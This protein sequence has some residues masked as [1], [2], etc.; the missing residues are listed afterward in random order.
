MCT[1]RRDGVKLGLPLSWRAYGLLLRAERPA[2]WVA[3]SVGQWPLSRL[4]SCGVLRPVPAGSD[5]FF[6]GSLGWNH[7]GTDPGA[8]MTGWRLTEPSFR[9]IGFS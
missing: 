9:R 7:S 1:L 6:R 2:S 4:H 5:S 3:P 8:G